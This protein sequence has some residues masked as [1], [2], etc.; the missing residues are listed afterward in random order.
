[1]HCPGILVL[2]HGGCLELF[3]LYLE[4]QMPGAWMFP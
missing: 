3:V 2:A 4:M 1:M